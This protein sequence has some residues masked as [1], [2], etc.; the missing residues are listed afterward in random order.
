MHPTL[1]NRHYLARSF[2]LKSAVRPQEIG[3]IRRWL[4]ATIRQWQRRR[5]IANFE[6]M[7]D[8]VLSDIGIERADIHSIVE[9]FDERELRMA[10]IAPPRKALKIEGE[11]FQ[12]AA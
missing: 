5:M 8:W 12:R 6:A 11:V 2:E 9:G 1:L 7:D 4:S 10:P 3:P